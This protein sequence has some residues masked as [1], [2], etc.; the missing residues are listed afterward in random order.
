MM[1]T[2]PICPEAVQITGKTEGEPGLLAVEIQERCFCLEFEGKRSH[3]YE[4]KVSRQLL[5]FNFLFDQF[6]NLRSFSNERLDVF[7]PPQK[8]SP[9]EF[10][11]N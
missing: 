3:L 2:C 6:E 7:K 9:A 8:K 4:K 10:D 1:S 11:G 5:G